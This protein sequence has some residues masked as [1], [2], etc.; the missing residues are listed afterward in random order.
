VIDLQTALKENET[1]SHEK[2]NLFTLCSRT[3]TKIL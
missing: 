1:R 2:N 3:S